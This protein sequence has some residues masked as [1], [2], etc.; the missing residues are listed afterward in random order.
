MLM[1]DSTGQKIEITVTVN[2]ELH[3]L[4]VAPNTLLVTLLRE[5]LGLTGTHVG[6]D[7]SQCGACTTHL[8]GAA[9][10]S[11]SVL[12]VQADDCEVVT[13]EAKDKFKV[14]PVS[15]SMQCV[16]SLTIQ[17]MLVYTALA[18]VRTAADTFNA[19]SRI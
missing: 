2:G 7:T 11:C 18:V 4:S 17:Y 12:A 6:C 15:T 1:S 5:H 14:N 8:D 19:T 16:I 9:V 13:I 10:K 3:G